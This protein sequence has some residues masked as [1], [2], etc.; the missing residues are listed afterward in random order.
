MYQS[1]IKFKENMWV[2]FFLK[3]SLRVNFSILHWTV[4]WWKT[5]TGS[6]TT[7]NEKL[8]PRVYGCLWQRSMLANVASK[9]R[10]LRWRMPRP[11]R[12]TPRASIVTGFPVRRCAPA[13][14]RCA[15]LPPPAGLW[16]LG[17][18]APDSPWAIGI[19]KLGQ[20]GITQ[21]ILKISW[22]VEQ[23]CSKKLQV[24]LVSNSK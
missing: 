3:V 19:D 11:A 20:P 2:V 8:K 7:K 4:N 14:S 9:P 16:E 5:N 24:Q 18:H 13:V 6:F 12:R 1:V 17:L 22:P 23:K 21:E 10:R 15:G